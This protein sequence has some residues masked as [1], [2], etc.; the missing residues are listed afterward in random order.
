M[1]KDDQ[2]VLFIIRQGYN[3]IINSNSIRIDK[4]SVEIYSGS[5]AFVYYNASQVTRGHAQ[6]FVATC[7]VYMGDVRICILYRCAV[8]IKPKYVCYECGI[9]LK[10]RIEESD[11]GHCSEKFL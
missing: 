9:S 7:I 1:V 4:F 10:H 6:I 11:Q 2:Q 8:G 3:N 5:F